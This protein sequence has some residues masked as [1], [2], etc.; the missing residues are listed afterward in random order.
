MVAWRQAQGDTFLHLVNLDEVLAGHSVN[1]KTIQKIV[2]SATIPIGIGGDI[3]P[4][5]AVRSTLDLEVRYVII[6]T[7][8]IARP[9]FPKD[10][11]EKLGE[12]AIMAGVDTRDGTVA[13]KGREKVSAVTAQ[14]LYIKMREFEVRHTVHMNISR[15]GMLSG[16]NMK[17]TR[18]LT[19][20]MGLDIIASGGT[21]CMKDLQD[22]H[23]AGIRGATIGKTLYESRTGLKETVRLYEN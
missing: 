4:E 6:G 8:V 3:R 13:V 19:E 11:V 14:D 20:G 10:M 16:P 17:A 12:G 21:P 22:P 5:G 18:Q 15:D 2:D 7:K 23:E 1:A 9:E